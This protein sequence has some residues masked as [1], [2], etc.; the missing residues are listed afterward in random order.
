M[1]KA[2]IGVLPQYSAEKDRIM[3]VADYFRAIQAAGGI[4]VLVPLEVGGEE[5]VDFLDGV[6]G[7]LLPGGPDIN[8]LWYGEETLPACGN[9]LPARDQLE[10]DLISEILQT[11]KPVM[12]ICRGIQTMNVALGG[13][14]Y[15]DIASGYAGGSQVGHSQ[16]AGDKVL[17]HTVHVRKGTMLYDIVKKESFAV[18][19]F[20]HQACKVMGRGFTVSAEAADG[21]VEAAE[22][23]D[24]RFFL[25]VQ[26]HAEHLYAVDE[27]A[28]RIWDAFVKTS[29]R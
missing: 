29:R 8:P 26:W 2:I 11:G 4:A 24:H 19:S 3:I 14:L 5:L 10:F 6:D 18:N 13:T 23:E 15:Q 1:G 28:A 9:I 7:F 25:G 12:G 16:R 27:A 21:I 22:L 20:H 17:T